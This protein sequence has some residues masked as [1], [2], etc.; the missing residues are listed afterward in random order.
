MIP[1]DSPSELRP[2]PRPDPSVPAAIRCRDLSLSYRGGKRIGPFTFTLPAGSCTALVGPN[3]S[4]K[5]TLLSLLLGLRR[6]DTGEAFLFG[7]PVSDPR[8]RERTGYLREVGEFF[9]RDRAE[10]LLALHAALT[11]TSLPPGHL[12]SFGLDSP[13]RRLKA[14]SK[15]MKQRLGLALAFLDA[16]R[17]LVLD[18]PNSG[19]DPRGIALLRERIKKAKDGGATV[20]LSTHRLAEVMNLADRVMVLHEGRVAAESAMEAF[21]DFDALERFFLDATA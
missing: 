7:L 1:A 14:F 6:P 20:L 18:E 13:P 10:D 12:E 21:T 15:G 3:G 8:S 19:L 9:G 16:S 5:S 2:G 11:G 4:G 17:L